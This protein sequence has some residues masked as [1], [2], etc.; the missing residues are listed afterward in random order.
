LGLGKV[1]GT[2][3]MGAVIGTGSYSLIDGSTVRT[4]GVGVYLADAKHTNMENYGVQPD[5]RVDNSPEDNLAGRDRQLETA[6]DELLRQLGSNKRNI[7]SKG[8]Q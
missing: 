2:P 7:A 1:I 6:V 5:I 4:P 3:T 8:E